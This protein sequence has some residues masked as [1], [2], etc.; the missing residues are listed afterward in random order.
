MLFTGIAA[1]RLWGAKGTVFPSDAGRYP[2]PLTSIDVY[3]LTS[4]QYST[5]MTA[6]YNRGIAHNSSWMLSCSDRTGSPQP[7][8]LDLK[9][10]EMKHLTEAEGLDGTTLTLTPDNRNYC[11]AAGRSIWL[12][13]ATGGSRDREIYRIAEGW[14]RAG[15][16]SVGP[17]RHACHPGGAQR[18]NLAAAPGVAHRSGSTH[19][20]RIAGRG[21][22]SDSR[23]R[24]APRSSTGSPRTTCG[25]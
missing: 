1:T 4:P 22:G 8:R 7:F 13:P 19:R 6:Y 9:N 12:A 5:T 16:I 24:C 21:A 17:G 23:G 14:E 25:W 10:G 20:D 15:G 18:G 3:R 11:F 2:D